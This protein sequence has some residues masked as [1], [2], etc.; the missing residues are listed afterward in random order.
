MVLSFS[1]IRSAATSVKDL[2]SESSFQFNP[3]Q[4]FPENSAKVH[5]PTI[6]SRAYGRCGM[7]T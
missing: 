1:G 7:T 2:E 4:R 6:R 5:Q 3:A